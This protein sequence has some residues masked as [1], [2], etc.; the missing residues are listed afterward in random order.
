MSCAFCNTV[1]NWSSALLPKTHGCAKCLRIWDACHWSKQMISDHRRRKIDLVCT[2][3]INNGYTVGNY[4]GYNCSECERTRGSMKYDRN[5]ILRFKKKQLEDLTCNECKSIQSYLKKYRCHA[6]WRY[7]DRNNW[8]STERKNATRPARE[9]S[10]AL[11]CKSCRQDGYDAKDLNT[12]RCT[13]CNKKGGGNK[14]NYASLRSFK[15]SHRDH[16]LCK[17]C[18]RRTRL[19][20]Q[21]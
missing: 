10:T 15:N 12:Y 11:V 13:T 1:S 9:K 20:K 18:S 4:I 21:I 19:K 7:F 2:P 3:C 14:F 5:D 8:T 6:C 17:D 16:L